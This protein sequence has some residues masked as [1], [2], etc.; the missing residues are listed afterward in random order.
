ME[1]YDVDLLE[2]EQCVMVITSTFGN[3]ESPDNGKV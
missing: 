3:G 2:E 1:D